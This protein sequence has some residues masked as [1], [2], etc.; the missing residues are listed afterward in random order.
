[1]LKL[2]Q[3]HI[4]KHDDCYL[5]I[6]P[7]MMSAVAA[8]EKQ[9]NLLRSLQ[10]RS[11]ETASAEEIKV[12][13]EMNIIT[14]RE[15]QDFEELTS[16]VDIYKIAL[17]I[18]QDCNFNCVYCY[19]AEEGSPVGGTYGKRGNMS[20]ITARSAIDWLITASGELDT[21]AI[22]FFGGEPLLNF[23]GMQDVVEYANKQ[24]NKYN[25]KIK[26]SIT[27]NAS[28]LDEDKIHFLK[29]NDVHVT[30]SMDGGLRIQDS[31]RPLPNGKGT[32]ELV[33]P[34]VKALLK[35]IPETVC[36]GTVFN[37]ADVFQAEQDLSKLGF[38]QVYLTV[39]S[40]SLLKQPEKEINTSS[41]VEVGLHRFHY[42]M[43]KA[44]DE[45]YQILKAIKSRDS[46]KLNQLIKNGAWARKIIRY[47]EQFVQ[48]K[49]THFPCGA[50]RHYVGVSAS[51]DIYPC[52]RF[53]GTESTKIGS[54]FN[55]ELNRSKYHQT[56][57]HKDNG[58]NCSSCFAKYVCSGGCHH[59]NMG[60]TGDVHGPDPEMCDLIR[61]VVEVSALISIKLTNQ[62][63]EYLESNKFY[64]PYNCPLDIF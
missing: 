2:E 54:I 61:E 36:R 23:I 48:R 41:K 16:K 5:V 63:K 49:K 62:D 57:L 56:T 38:K 32:Y 18:S 51:G 22:G 10:S 60:A 19:G 46:L 21:I 3:H 20:A 24:A 7:N 39:A 43:Q 27:T 64:Q 45:A 13:N 55:G 9:I 15:N 40:P 53:V 8:N 30:V 47:S 35:E 42:S 4:S 14:N 17:F 50:G 37:D 34:K 26:Y 29:D 11:L 25:K 1:M 31:Q 44:K 12:L 6:L 28:L 58:N 59:D 52:H 33:E